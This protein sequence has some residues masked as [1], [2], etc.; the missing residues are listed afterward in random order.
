[1]RS[2]RPKPLHLLCGRPMLLYVLDALADCDVDRA[3][4]VVGHGAER[5][6]K[7]LQ[8]PS[9]RPAPRASSSSTCSGA[10]ATPSA[11]ASPRFPDD[12]LDDD[13]DV[14]VLPGD[15]PLLRPATIAAPRRGPPRDRRRVH[16]PHRPP[17]RPDRLRPHRPRQ[18]RPGRRGSSSSATPPPTSWRST[19]STRRSTASAAACSAPALR[20]LSPDNAQGEYYLTDV[21]EVLHD[22]GYPVVRGRR[23]RRRRDRRASTTG[24]SWPRPR[25]SCAAAPTSAGCRRASRCSTPT[26]TYIDATVAA[27][28][29]TSPCSPARSCRAARVVGDGAEIGP[30]TRLVDCVVGAGRGRR[31]DRRPRRRDRRRRR[32]SVRSPCSQPGAVGAV[33]RR[34]RAVLHCGRRR[35]L[36]AEAR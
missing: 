11:S 16:R 2:A 5:V 26:S 35:R 14:L 7:K 15:T 36:T 4:V 9:P 10:P 6:T 12:D 17:R 1:M 22:A 13:G 34:H 23:R 28:P 25:P 20:R 31:A 19:R 30:D 18:G 32:A 29:P 27:R 24:C 3:V 21:V 8:E 33:R